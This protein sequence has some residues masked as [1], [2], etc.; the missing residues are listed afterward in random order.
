MPPRASRARS[1][2]AP[3]PRI[4]VALLR[5]ELRLPWASVREIIE[6]GAATKPE[7]TMAYSTLLYDKTDR[8]AKI[9]LNRPKYRNAQSTALLKELDRAFAE[10]AE[11][12]DVRVVILAGAGDHFSSGHDLGT[13]DERADQ[14][15]YLNI[16]GHA[17]RHG[18]SWEVFLDNTLRWRDLPKATIAQVQGYCI[19]CPR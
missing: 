9:T 2:D 15:S 5:E 18:K 6:F 10:A 7:E 1:A 8:I 14:S 4:V 16:R 17:N 11:D 3:R 19:S 13:P 12:R